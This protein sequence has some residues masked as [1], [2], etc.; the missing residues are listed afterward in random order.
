[1]QDRHNVT[2]A[3]NFVAAHEP[4][5][6]S[7]PSNDAVSA[8]W[9]DNAGV[10]IGTFA[11]LMGAQVIVFLALYVI[12]WHDTWYP[13]WS[14]LQQWAVFSFAL[15][16][17]LFGLLMAWRSS[18]DEREKA[19]ELMYWQG[20]V[21][22]AQAD[23]EE[24]AARI[25]ELQQRLDMAQVEL[26]DQYVQMQVAMRSAKQFVPE[27]PAASSEPVPIAIYRDAA[28]LASLSLTPG[29]EYSR[30]KVCRKYSWTTSRWYA[31]RDLLVA[32]NVWAKGDKTTEILAQSRP[33]G[34]AMLSLYAGHNE[35]AANVPDF[36]DES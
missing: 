19:G 27:A 35:Q 6:R 26:R 30:D 18:L 31:A 21:E 23:L 33:A 36:S 8:K 15:G 11:A 9:K 20:L 34:L 32:A 16:M 24:A 29:M 2:S 14:A 7:A 5:P 22:Q 13:P 3:P 1:M 10:W 25:E 12:G 28:L 17:I 4:A